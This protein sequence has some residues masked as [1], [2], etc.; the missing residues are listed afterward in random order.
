[1]I[2]AVGR[3]RWALVEGV[4]IAAILTVWLVVR[5][6][7]EVAVALVDLPVTGSL[8]AALVSTTD[9][10]VG[11]LGPLALANVGLYVTVRAGLII[12]DRHSTS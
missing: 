2:P 5:L 9:A 6:L 4:V 10:V 7:F 8:A 1:M 12:V 3:V 11:L